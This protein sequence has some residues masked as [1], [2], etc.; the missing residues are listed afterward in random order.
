MRLVYIAIKHDLWTKFSNVFIQIKPCSSTFK[1]TMI[2][3]IQF[4]KQTYFSFSG[5]LIISR[6]WKKGGLR[7]SP[8]PANDSRKEKLQGQR[9][10][11]CSGDNLRD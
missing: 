9:L 5:I 10:V 4:A 2:S 3:L 1:S 7:T 8:S 6:L 11:I